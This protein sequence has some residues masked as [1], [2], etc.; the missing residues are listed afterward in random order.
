MFVLKKN[1]EY[2]FFHQSAKDSQFIEIKARRASHSKSK[3]ALDIFGAFFGLI[4]LSPLLLAITVAIWMQDRGRILF[5]QER[6]GHGGKRFLIYKFRTMHVS[7][8]GLNA[9]Q[10]QSQDQ[11]I[12]RLGGWLRKTS[13]DEL[14]QLWNVLVGTMSLVGP[15]PHAIN[16][17]A[18]FAEKVP[19]YD[20]RFLVRPG[21]T[22]LAQTTGLR[23][24][25]PT[26]SSMAQRVHADHAYISDWSLLAD[27]RIII[28]TLVLM[29]NDPVAF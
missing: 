16:H 23:G 15:R 19:G 12:T 10:A 13:L 4:V 27:V 5:A 17:D 28:K 21:I 7:E 11:R 9:V 2:D 20:Q 24:P 8:N 1:N 29:F 26:L 18:F 25:T 14:P 22:G 6:T 3:R